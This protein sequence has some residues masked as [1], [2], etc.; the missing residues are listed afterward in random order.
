MKALLILIFTFCGIALTYEV[1]DKLEGKKEDNPYMC[2]LSAEMHV[3]EYLDHD[4]RDSVIV[5]SRIDIMLADQYFDSIVYEGVLP[6]TAI[7]TI[8][9]HGNVPY[10]FWSYF[11]QVNQ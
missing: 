11:T 10:K 6:V 7:A 5:V 9:A 3:N 1:V 4:S 2:F 8:E